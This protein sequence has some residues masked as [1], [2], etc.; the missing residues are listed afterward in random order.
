MEIKVGEY[1]RTKEWGIAKVHKVD[2]GKVTWVKNKNNRVT[3]YFTQLKEPSKDLI[4]L[5]EVGDIVELSDVLHKD[6][7]YVWSKR[8]IKA[9]K[10][11]I[12]NGIQLKSILTKE[13]FESIKYVVGD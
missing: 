10:E 9:L 11:D 12:E 6:I 13:Q 1:V 4:D 5:I 3:H 2:N 8:M 7:L